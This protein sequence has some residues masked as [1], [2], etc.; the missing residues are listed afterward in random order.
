[1][2]TA[3]K[4]VT[5]LDLHRRDF[6]KRVQADA[7]YLYARLCLPRD[8]AFIASELSHSS[9][10][11]PKRI[12][13]TASFQPAVPRSSGMVQ[14]QA[15]CQS[16]LTAKN[17]LGYKRITAARNPPSCGRADICVFC[18]ALAVENSRYFYYRGR[19]LVQQRARLR[20]T[21]DVFRPNPPG[22]L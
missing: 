14:R 11:L 19:D 12:T 3:E 4:T 10:M 2:I 1:M 17:L 22:R 6:L 9:M 8:H 15:V 21:A 16:F 5:H 18:S 13:A 7:F 20:R